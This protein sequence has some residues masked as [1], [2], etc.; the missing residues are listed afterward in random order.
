MDSKQFAM[1]VGKYLARVMI[2]PAERAEFASIEA[3]LNGLAKGEL[4]IGKVQPE[5]PPKDKKK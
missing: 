4:V 3:A 5:K 1:S 2:A